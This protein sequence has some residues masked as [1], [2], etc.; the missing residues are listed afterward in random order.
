[1]SGGRWLLLTLG[2]AACLVGVTAATNAFIDPYGLFR[3]VQQRSLGAPGDPRVA[4]YLLALRY[5]PEKFD[6]L[7]SGASIA[8][9]WDVTGIHSLRVYNVAMSGSNIVEERAIMENAIAHR[10]MTL[11]ILLVHPAMTSSHEFHTVRMT[12]ELKWSALGSASLA[13]AYKD[14]IN[15]R[16]GRSHPTFDGSGTEVG[17]VLHDVMNTNMKALWSA[18]TFQVDSIALRQYLDLVHDLRASGTRVIFL[19]PPT[20]RSLLAT[21]RAPMESYVAAMR[22]QVGPQALWIDLMTPP[23]ASLSDDANFSDGVHLR[24]AA[25]RQVVAAIDSSI[26]GWQQQG[27]LPATSLRALADKLRPSR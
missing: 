7:L 2:L 4:K 6:G 14:M 16:L 20:G 13:A 12:P 9:G 3:P 24:P 8:A 25:A 23:Y 1:M 5:V 15:I 10:G 18:P 11:A 26:R 17:M 22:Q 21:K 19:V 27:Q